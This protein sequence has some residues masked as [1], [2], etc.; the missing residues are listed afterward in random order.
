MTVQF[1]SMVIEIS[2]WMYDV[3]DVCVFN[4]NSFFFKSHY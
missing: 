1:S 2:S 4:V 3:V